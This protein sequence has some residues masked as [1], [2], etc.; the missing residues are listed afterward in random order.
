MRIILVEE[1][2]NNTSLDRF[3][4]DLSQNL[5]RLMK[6]NNV[7]ESE[8]SRALGLPYNTIH[9][10][11]SG[12]TTDP[13]ISTLK[14]IAAYFNVSLD[15]LFNPNSLSYVNENMKS[16]ES[17]INEALLHYILKHSHRLYPATQGTNSDYADFVLELF[18]EVRS[19][20]TSESTLLKIIDLAIS[21][22]SLYEEKN[23][24]FNH[25]I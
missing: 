10:L 11:I 17:E 20:D 2:H 4:N 13:R 15:A 23:K 8:L 3:N 6:E 21:S 5:S 19:I 12:D 25:V 1:L 7:S 22:I 18:R 16:E 24:K 14:S 9:R